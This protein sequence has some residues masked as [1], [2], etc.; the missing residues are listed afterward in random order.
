MDWMPVPEYK[1][2][3]LEC[4]QNS[5]TIIS[6]NRLG[7]SLRTSVTNSKRS[8]IGAFLGLMALCLAAKASEESPGDE[9]ATISVDE[10]ALELSNP[11]TALRSLAWDIEY[12]TYQ[13]DL[14]AANDQTGITNVFTTSWPIKLSNGKSL[15]LSATL[16]IK[17]DQPYWKPV[18]YLDY[19]DFVIRQ[20]PNIDE[21][22]GG[23]GSGHD[24]MGD[25][26]IDI[27]YGGVNESGFISMLGLATVLPTSEDTSA[28]RQQWLLGPEIALGQVTS[29]GLLSA[30]VKHLTNIDGEG[31]Q[32]LGKLDTNET[33]LKLFF[34]YALG[35][36][37]QIESNPI[38]LYDW[39]AVSGNEWTVPIGAGVS[40][41][42]IGAAVGAR[43]RGFA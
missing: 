22:M 16:P 28:A 9:R 8:C 10:I 43:A 41:T 18:F 42:I 1:R 38:I 27:G 17:G 21:T 30:R 15:L 11:V 29:W 13:G 7:E 23:F 4:N 34:A 26:G 12:R 33:T 40:K 3:Y 31:D 19:D 6:T 24:H 39:E 35:N 20:L 25:I 37:W 5:K 36:G 2:R 32:E 14:P